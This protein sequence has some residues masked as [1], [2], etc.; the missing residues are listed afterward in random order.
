MSRYAVGQGIRIPITVKDSTGTLTNATSQSLVLTKPNG[1]TVTYSS[2]TNDSTGVYHQDL[3][4]SDIA[5]VG[6]YQWV[7]TVVVGSTQGVL[8]GNF[9]VFDP[10][11]VSLLP[12]GDAKDALNIPQAT[13]TYDVEVAGYVASIEAE[14]E[15]LCGG[16]IVT[17][18]ISQERVQVRDNYRQLPLRYRPVVSVTAITDVASGTSIDLSDIEV[19]TNAGIVRRKLNLQ[20]WAR[21]P[22]YYVTYTAGFGTSVPA[23][24]NTAARLI[25]Q[26]LWETQRGPSPVPAFGGQ[27]DQPQPARF[28]IANH[29]AI[30]LLGSYLQEAYV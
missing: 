26:D 4:L 20:F 25:L 17:R 28:E 7:D 2:P 22:F 13:T 27:N 14:L 23:A 21:G 15:R 9:D 10:A 18:S 3:T 12:L 30:G 24:F 29:Q 11:E 6:H 5:S 19:D 1:T 8:F 16:P